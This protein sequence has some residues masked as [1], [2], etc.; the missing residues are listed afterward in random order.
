MPASQSTVEVKNQKARP[1]SDC[2]IAQQ[3]RLPPSKDEGVHVG[4]GDPDLYLER[5]KRIARARTRAPAILRY[6]S[7]SRLPRS[8]DYVG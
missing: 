1:R 8:A 5:G 3:P 4:W 2:L 6:I 7:G